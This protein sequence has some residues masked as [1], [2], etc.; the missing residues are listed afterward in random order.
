MIIFFPITKEIMTAITFCF[1]YDD[2]I[3]VENASN[4]TKY[5]G[6]DFMFIN[7]KANMEVQKL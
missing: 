1:W 3:L 6:S 2:V 7:W 4:Q 5:V